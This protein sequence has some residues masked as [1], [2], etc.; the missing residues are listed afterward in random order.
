MCDILK[1]AGVVVCLCPLMPMQFHSKMMN[2][3]DLETTDGDEQ[4]GSDPSLALMDSHLPEAVDMHTLPTSPPLPSLPRL[5]SV[6]P[7]TLWPHASL[8]AL[9]STSK[10][11]KTGSSGSTGVVSASRDLEW[12]L[13]SRQYDEK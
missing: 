1:E 8:D 10:G 2:L 3:S 11:K 4:I 13:E 5:A 6:A 9:V 12:L 7:S